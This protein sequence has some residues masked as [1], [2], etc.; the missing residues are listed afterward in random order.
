[1]PWVHQF[2]KLLTTLQ[3]F[4]AAKLGLMIGDTAIIGL[5]L[6]MPIAI[7][8]NDKKDWLNFA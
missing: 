6:A 5:Y 4:I 7:N 3:D 1:M 8:Q 2:I